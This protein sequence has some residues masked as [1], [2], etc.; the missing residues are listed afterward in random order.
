VSGRR[1]HPPTEHS[2]LIA[3]PELSR[4][5]DDIDRRTLRRYVAEGVLRPPA[6]IA[7]RWYFRLADVEQAE[8]FLFAEGAREWIRRARKEGP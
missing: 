6:R 7:G 1:I 2:K 5:W 4:R 3:L 8:A